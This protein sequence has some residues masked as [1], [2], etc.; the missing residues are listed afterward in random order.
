MSNGFLEE[1]QGF[2][3][4]KVDK[5]V[6]ILNYSMVNGLLNDYL[7][8]LSGNDN[9]QNVENKS[10]KR[11][12]DKH[13]QD[14]SLKEVSEIKATESWSKRIQLIFNFFYKTLIGLN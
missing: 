2:M 7:F 11:K 13:T 3:K 1:H 12:H 6:L 10:S 14:E 9:D 4:Y 8:S 5:D